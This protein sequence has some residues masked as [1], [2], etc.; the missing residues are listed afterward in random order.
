VLLSLVSTVSE[1]LLR[2]VSKTKCTNCAR[3]IESDPAWAGKTTTCFVLYR[4]DS[5]NFGRE[6]MRETTT[7]LSPRDIQDFKSS[8]LAILFW[9]TVAKAI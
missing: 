3:R 8:R 4:I 7:V 1:F 6:L 2:R 9:T 5:I